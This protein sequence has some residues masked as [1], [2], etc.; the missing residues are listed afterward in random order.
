MTPSEPRRGETPAQPMPARAG[1]RPSPQVASIRQYRVPRHPAPTDL[2]LDGNEGQAPGGDCLRALDDLVP[3]FARY[4]STAALA[5]ALAAR[6]GVDES[7]VL[8]CAGA[9]DA[10]D[11]ACRALLAPGR[12]AI[13][14]RP[15][16]EML[17]RYV[18]LA[19]VEPI[20]IDWLTG[21]FPVEAMLERTSQRTALMTVVSPN[22]PTGSVA[23]TGDVER[24]CA[25]APHVAVLVDQAYGEFADDDLTACALAQ[26]NALVFRTFSKAGGLASLRVGYVLGAAEVLAWL[27]AAGTPYPVAG[28]SLALAERSLRHDHTRSRVFVAEVRR[29]RSELSRDLQALGAR[30]LP[31]QGNFVLAFLPDSGRVF[32]AF[33][34][35]GIAVRRFPDQ[36][37]LA[38]A[39]RITCPGEPAAFAR[40]QHALRSALAPQ[41]VLFDLDGVLA[42]VSHSYRQTI[43][44]TAQ[45]YGV[46]LTPADI[47]T[48][49]AEGNANDD[50]ALTWRLLAAR[51]VRASLVD[52]TARFEA[53]YQGTSEVP[54]LRRH[55]T[56]RLPR[57]QLAELARRLPLAVV[58]GRPRA[59]AERFLAEHGIADLFATCVCREDAALKP[60]PA[61]VRLALARLGVMRAWLLGDSV[62][63]VRAARGAAVIPLGVVAPGE[64]PTTATAALLQAGAARVANEPG[65]HL[66]CLLTESAPPSPCTADGKATPPRPQ[67]P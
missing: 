35:L 26:A 67:R 1:L 15:S 13:L 3:T 14:T 55:E 34:G 19:G 47:A 43:L 12:E 11:R 64:D 66:T 20:E 61:P 36:P 16:F 45:A 37:E 62:D 51:G 18:R 54:G 30:P 9:D 8:V 50:W 32:D 31:S 58:T 40:V 48:A 44:A 2:R 25:A 27:R 52:V 6:H 60:D 65:T 28:P 24:L 38:D 23:T 17:P 41:A 56:L 5:A 46:T 4:P 33:A 63:D 10:L 42:D 21:P 22:N 29:Q 7:R 49:K 59:D 53:I 39:L 57:T